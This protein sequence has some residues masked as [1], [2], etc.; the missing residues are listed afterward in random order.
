VEGDHVVVFPDDFRRN[1]SRDDFFKN[2]HGILSASTAC[3][4]IAKQAAWSAEKNFGM[5]GH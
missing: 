5:S 3:S 4:E 2:R 1:L